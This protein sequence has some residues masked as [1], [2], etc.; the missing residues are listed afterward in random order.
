[1]STPPPQ[2]QNQPPYGQPQQP[3]GQQQQPYGYP[4]QQQVRT[5]IRSSRS[6]PAVLSGFS[7]EVCCGL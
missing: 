5:D 4:Q 1:M 3:Y 7:R 6:L 2:Y